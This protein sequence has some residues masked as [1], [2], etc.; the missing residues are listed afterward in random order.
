MLSVIIEKRSRS[1][2]RYRQMIKKALYNLE[3][4]A[5]LTYIV[6][7]AGYQLVTIAIPIN[8]AAYNHDIINPD[9]NTAQVVLQGDKVK[10]APAF[11]MWHVSNNNS[12][13]ANLTSQYRVLY[14]C[15]AQVFFILRSDL[16]NC[17]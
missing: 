5:K 13:L 1:C 4:M 12:Y 15:Y 2:P 17:S 3:N 14:F 9:M 10:I 8:A 7:Y 11:L 6:F 16:L